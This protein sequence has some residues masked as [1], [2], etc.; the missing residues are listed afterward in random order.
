MSQASKGSKQATGLHPDMCKPP[1]S[2]SSSISSHGSKRTKSNSHAATP[3]PD[4]TEGGII[5]NETLSN[6]AG[7]LLDVNSKPGVVWTERENRENMNATQQERITI[8]NVCVHDIFPKLKFL[9]CDHQLDYST[10]DNSLCQYVLAKCSVAHMHNQREWWEKNR[11]YV[12]K[13]ITAE[14]SNKSSCLRWEF[15]GK[16]KTSFHFCISMFLIC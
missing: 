15:F 16:Y 11:K 8:A 3:T 6:I 14:H 12:V 9:N 1:A 7:S 4:S 2:S 5:L 13:K 10:E